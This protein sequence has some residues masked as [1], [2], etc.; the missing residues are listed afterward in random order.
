MP[1]TADIIE[2]SDPELL[3][4]LDE[5]DDS[6]EP[7]V[8]VVRLK[9]EDASQIVPPP[10]RTAEIAES[11]L[12]RVKET[13]GGEERHNVFKN[14]GYFVVAASRPFL[15]ELISQPEVA[16]VIANVQ[17]G[18]AEVKP[19]ERRPVAPTTPP[20]AVKRRGPKK[21]KARAAARKP[22]GK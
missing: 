4:Q 9:P 7:V 5:D 16:R 13:V 10:E 1:F 8:A 11:V 12:Q 21:A 22:A 18:G 14:L 19:V 3:R 20:Q 2:K 17:P 15:R 6:D